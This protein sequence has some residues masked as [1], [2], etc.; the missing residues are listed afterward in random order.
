MLDTGLV[1]T[2]LILAG[3]HCN[4]DSAALSDLRLLI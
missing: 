2:D 1:T 3:D 4:L